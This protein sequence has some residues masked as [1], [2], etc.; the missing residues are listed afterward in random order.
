MGGFF[1]ERRRWYG[2]ASAAAAPNPFAARRGS[3]NPT[4]PAHAKSPREG[5]F[6]RERRRRYGGAS[7]A[8]G[9]NPFAARRGFDNPTAP[10]HGKSPHKG[11]FFRERRR[12]DSNPRTVARH[13][14]SSQGRY[15][16]FDTPPRQE[17]LY[18]RFAANVKACSGRGGDCAQ[19]LTLGG[20]SDLSSVSST[21]QNLLLTFSPKPTIM[22][23]I[24]LITM[25]GGSAWKGR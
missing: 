22:K 7:A 13:L 1:R 3:D 19:D 18:P 14:I 8:A 2:G 12:W 21:N 20:N 17:S 11:G 5:G 6:L 24:S 4:A 16:H 9:P 23:E 15:D 25:G 10:A